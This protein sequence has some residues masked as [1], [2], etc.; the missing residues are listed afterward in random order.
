MV[1]AQ[2]NNYN[3]VDGDIPIPTDDVDFINGSLRFDFPRNETL[4]CNVVQ[5]VNDSLALE[6][7]EQFV[8]SI[9][10]LSDERVWLGANSTSTVF[11]EDDD[12]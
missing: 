4:S 7:H 10:D 8:I 11:I 2:L 12:G 1:S 9:S 3:H 5:V 6:G